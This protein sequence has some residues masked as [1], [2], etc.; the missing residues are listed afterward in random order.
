M[1]LALLGSICALIGLAGCSH[2]HDDHCY[3]EPVLVH[4]HVE[5]VDPYC[6]DDRPYYHEHR[7]VRRYRHYDRY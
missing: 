1:R 5:V 7:V 3:D 2:Y 4:R 6:H